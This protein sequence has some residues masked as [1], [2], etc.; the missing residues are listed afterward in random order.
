MNVSK[1]LKHWALGFTAIVLASNLITIEAAPKP[2]QTKSAVTKT[3]TKVVTPKP[4]VTVT[5]TTVKGQPVD[6]FVLGD[7]GTGLSGQFKISKAMTDFHAKSPIQFIV[8]VGDNIY[9]DGDINAL[10]QAFYY[11]PYAA[12]LKQKIHFYATLGNH[13]V[14]H[15][16]D[17]IKFFNM[18][19]R[20]YSFTKGNT[21]FFVTDTNNFNAEE[22][23]WLNGALAKSTAKWKIVTGHHPVYSHGPHG[24]EKEPK[25]LARDLKPILEKHHVDFYLSGHDHDYE[26]FKPV[27]GVYYIVAGGGGASLRPL[28]KTTLATEATVS[29]VEHHYMWVRI[30]GNKFYAK[31]LGPNNKIIDSFYLQK[32]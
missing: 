6:F 1:S 30:D 13:D 27:N 7:W 3:T 2:A 28:E 11:K 26:R 23:A 16:A 20:Y 32:K 5:S 25:Q 24:Q 17:Q 4:T 18:P 22:M 31:A 29:K 12:L 15:Q 21:Q 8:T 14:P 19:G 10:A 9:P